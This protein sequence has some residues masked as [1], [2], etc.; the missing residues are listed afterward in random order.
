MSLLLEF[1]DAVTT[2]MIGVESG[3]RVGRIGRASDIDPFILRLMEIGE[4]HGIERCGEDSLCQGEEVLVFAVEPLVTPEG[5]GL[6][7]VAIG[8]LETVGVAIERVERPYES[9]LSIAGSMEGGWLEAR[10]VAPRGWILLTTAP[11]ERDSLLA[12]LVDRAI[13]EFEGSSVR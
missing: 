4:P 6:A 8:Q 13:A 12:E 10:V 9:V 3:G 11:S 1:L 5:K 7:D 2:V